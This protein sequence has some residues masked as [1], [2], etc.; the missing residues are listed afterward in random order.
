LNEEC[1]AVKEEKKAQNHRRESVRKKKGEKNVK[2]KHRM[3]AE[4]RK[5]TN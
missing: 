4:K 3:K 2:P 5:K 1:T